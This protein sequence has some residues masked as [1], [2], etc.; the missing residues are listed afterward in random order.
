VSRE[1]EDKNGEL[2]WAAEENTADARVGSPGRKMLHWRMRRCRW[3]TS[4][5]RRA[6]GW[7]GQR[8]AKSGWLRRCG[9]KGAGRRKVERE[10][11]G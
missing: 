2:R 7:R 4:S 9:R 5:R 10:E 11:R 3:G 8:C 1:V 6:G